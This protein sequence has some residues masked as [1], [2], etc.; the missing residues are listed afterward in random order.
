MPI[1][2]SVLPAWLWVFRP[3]CPPILAFSCLSPS[4]RPEA[5]MPSL[6]SSRSDLVWDGD[7]GRS[8][9]GLPPGAL[10]AIT[11]QAGD[12]GWWR[13]RHLGTGLLVSMLRGQE[14]CPGCPAGHCSFGSWHDGQRGGS[15]QL[16][17]T[18]SWIYSIPSL[19][20]G[21]LG[22]GA[23]AVVGFQ[24]ETGNTLIMDISP[25]LFKARSLALLPCCRCLLKGQLALSGL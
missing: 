24:V 14:R 19:S 11:G 9:F 20:K 5:E 21:G 12:G 8:R 17:A 16:L 13:P 10:S 25:T 23:G 3:T 6:G 15:G 18:L 22:D 2:P 7:P 4:H 1:A